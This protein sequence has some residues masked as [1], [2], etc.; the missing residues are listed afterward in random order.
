MTNSNV[1]PGCAS[2]TT[3]RSENEPIG[4]DPVLANSVPTVAGPAG[5]SIVSRRVFFPC[6]SPAHT[7]WV[8]E[9]R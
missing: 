6:R 3:E 9:I 1:L 5:A 4:S 8:R 2:V 7:V